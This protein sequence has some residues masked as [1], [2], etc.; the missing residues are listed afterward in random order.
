MR[1]QSLCLGLVILGAC[2]TEVG[3]APVTE[4]AA[5]AAASRVLNRVVWNGGGARVASFGETSSMGLDVYENR[6]VGQPSTAFLS[7]W[8]NWADPASMLCEPVE[9]CRKCPEPPMPGEPC[10]CGAWTEEYCRY[11]R[12]GWQYAWA[13]IPSADF[14]VKG[15]HATL[16]TTITPGG[17][18]SLERCEVD[19]LAGTFICAPD[20]GGTFRGEW[21]RN[22][23]TDFRSGGTYDTRSGKYAFH[24]SGSSNEA[25]ADFTGS[26]LGEDF[27]GQGSLGTGV[28]VTLERSVAARR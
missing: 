16:D 28:S 3:P 6:Q 23:L 24:S 8:R 12:Y 19:E 20:S 22:G 25:G 18:A 7:F 26:L 13:R 5:S 11:T 14:R 21:T 10:P 15:A 4:G 1:R 9:I 27:Q 2:G 17:E